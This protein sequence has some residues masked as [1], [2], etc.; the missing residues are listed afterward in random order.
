MLKKIKSSTCLPFSQL[1]LPGLN[2]DCLD[3]CTKLLS[4]NPGLVYCLINLHVFLLKQRLQRKQ[5]I[6][7]LRTI[8]TFVPYRLCIVSGQ[9]LSFHEFSRHK[10]LR[11]QQW[12]FKSHANSYAAYS[13]HLRLFSRLA[14]MDINKKVLS[15]KWKKCHFPLPLLHVY[16]MEVTT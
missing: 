11:W 16:L 4:R 15:E 7:L 5:F 9:R 8:S 13:L 6:N 10:F 12:G 14:D 2:P 3:I 1:I